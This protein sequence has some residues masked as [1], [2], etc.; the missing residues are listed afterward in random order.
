MSTS[1]ISLGDGFETLLSRGVPDLK[2]DLFIIDP[3][4]AQVGRSG[5]G[6]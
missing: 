3:E 2:F 1:V 6:G 4:F 5:G